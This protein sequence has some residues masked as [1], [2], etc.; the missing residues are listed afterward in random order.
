MF[1]WAP[2]V[3]RYNTKYNTIQIQNTMVEE[4]SLK[5]SEGTQSASFGLIGVVGFLGVREL[6]RERTP[7]SETPR[8]APTTPLEP[9]DPSA[10]RPFPPHSPSPKPRGYRQGSSKENWNKEAVLGWRYTAAQLAKLG[11]TCAPHRKRQK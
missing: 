4:Q 1:V 9:W 7:T 3:S 10:Y 2:F 8:V 6:T 5:I 11:E